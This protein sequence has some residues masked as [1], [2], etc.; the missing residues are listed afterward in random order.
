MATDGDDGARASERDVVER[1]ESLARA[2]ADADALAS[3]ARRSIRRARARFAT[4]RRRETRRLTTTTTTTTT[5]RAQRRR[6]CE[7]R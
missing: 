5:G 1:V 4:T 6:G 2:D 7:E 3:G